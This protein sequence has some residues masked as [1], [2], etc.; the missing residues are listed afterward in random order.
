VGSE[1]ARTI[2][3]A[4][5][6]GVRVAEREEGSQSAGSIRTSR[7]GATVDVLA[8]QRPRPQYLHVQ[9]RYELLLNQSHSPEA[10]Y[11]TLTHELGHLYCGHLGTPNPRW[12]PDRPGLPREAEE[13]EAE[14]VSYL[15]CMRRGLKPPSARYLHGYLSEDKAV[16]ALS[17]DGVLKAAGL[18]EQ[19]G[20][21]RLPLRKPGAA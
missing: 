11:A 1:L 9:V 5:R 4:K 20:R 6:D 14:C 12:W 21:E 10:Q 15:V 3:N 18:I 19:M 2:E 17:L 7:S 13:F 8:R 16:P